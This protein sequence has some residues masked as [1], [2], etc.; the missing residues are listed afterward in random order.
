MNKR[1]PHNTLFHSTT[2][3]FHFTI[4]AADVRSSYVCNYMTCAIASVT[5]SSSCS[6][7]RD[8][9]DPAKRRSSLSQRRLSTHALHERIHEKTNRLQ[10][11]CLS[12][13][14]EERTA[15]TSRGSPPAPPERAVWARAATPAPA[16][17]RV[18]GRSSPC[19]RNLNG[20]QCKGEM[21]R[22]RPLTQTYIGRFKSGLERLQV[23][24]SSRPDVWML[25]VLD[26][27]KAGEVE[28]VGVARLALAAVA[29]RGGAGLARSRFPPT[30]SSRRRR[31][32]GHAHGE[33]ATKGGHAPAVLCSTR[34]YRD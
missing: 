4:P 10:L 34:L 19:R 7:R 30:R 32:H 23:R 5:T 27:G 6:R 1:T 8:E 25:T 2:S 15:P 16:P 13:R 26:A 24:A 12:C 21:N 33:N 9:T 31:L 28:E 18:P 3:S 22:V 11:N 17:G 29:E 20:S 14:M